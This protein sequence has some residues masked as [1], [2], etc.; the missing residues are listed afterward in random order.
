MLEGTISICPECDG[1]KYLPSTSPDRALLGVCVY[2]SQEINIFGGPPCLPEYPAHVIPS[3]L[4]SSD[5][6]DK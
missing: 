2:C 5:S 3:T 6:G 1:A 4:P